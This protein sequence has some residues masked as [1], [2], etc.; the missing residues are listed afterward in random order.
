[1]LAG[2]S[3]RRRC[4]SQCAC[5]G[6]HVETIGEQG[7]RS[8][9]VSGSNFTHHHHDCQGHNPQGSLGIVVVPCAQEV[10]AVNVISCAHF[11]LTSNIGEWLPG[12]LLPPAPVPDRSDPAWRRAREHGLQ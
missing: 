3:I 9:D 1:M 5:V 4:N 10:V 12:V 11:F 8:G 6:C 7:H 2:K